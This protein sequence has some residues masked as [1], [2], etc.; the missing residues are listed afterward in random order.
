MA[1]SHLTLAALATAAVAG[2]DVRQTGPHGSI[3][4]GDYDSARLL[5]AGGE[6]WI[7]RM[8]RSQRAEAQQSADLVAIRA[9]ST[10]IRSR[11]TFSVPTYRGQ[12]PIADTRAIVYD[13]LEGSPLHVGGVMAG[14]GLPSAVGAAIAAIHMLPTSFVTD[15]G[16]TSHTP[17][18][19]MRS[20]ASVVDRA[21][22][23][24]LLPAALLERW[25]GAIQDSKLWQFQPTVINGSLEAESFL[26][27]DSGVRA[28]LGWQD[29]Q[30]GDPARDLAW[31]L[32]GP[33][34]DSID[35]VF[36][37]YNASRDT[38]ERS[39][40]HRATLYHELDL[41]R[42][43]LHG[44]HTKSTEVVDDAI[45]MMSR[46]VDVIQ[47]PDERPLVSGATEALDLEG[48][49]DLLTATERRHG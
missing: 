21:A 10:G 19:A 42:Y 41:A 35:S 40:R 17:F 6:Q 15:A 33:T 43:L 39:L 18:E 8:P 2:I 14:T 49:E 34:P 48:V 16:L 24:G 32:G 13:Y 4:S 44:T 3:G 9:L 45:E 37:A 5:G 27:D 26:V 12:A 47:Q 25:E 46:L 31:V 38:S 29:L 30:V 28:V 23:T 7:I 1:R 20:S 36:E 11:L 22:A